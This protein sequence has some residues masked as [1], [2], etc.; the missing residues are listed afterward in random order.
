MPVSLGPIKNGVQSNAFY[1][2]KAGEVL[3][4]AVVHVSNSYRDVQSRG[5]TKQEK[6]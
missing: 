6:Y 1:M 4:K 5:N 2:H 3:R